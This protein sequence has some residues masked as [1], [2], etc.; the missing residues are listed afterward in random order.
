M[1]LKLLVGS[2][3]EYEHFSNLFQIL[4]REEGYYVKSSSCKPIKKDL[5]EMIITF[6]SHMEQTKFY[7]GK[8]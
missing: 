7:N 6:Y 1:K 2:T 8:D 4:L 5:Y 3:V